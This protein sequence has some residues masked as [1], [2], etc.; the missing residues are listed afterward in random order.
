M[1]GVI[2]LTGC[3]IIPCSGNQAL[4]QITP[5]STLGPE[6]SVV[7]PN[8]LFNDQITEQIDGGAIRGTNLFHS[9]LEFNV[10]NGQQVYFANPI[11]IK[12]IVSRVTGTDS[13]DI[14]GT[15]GVGGGANLFLLNPNG[16][17]FGPNAKLDIGGSFLGSTADS[18]VF[19]NG[20]QFSATNP[21]APPLLTIN[22]PIGL[23][24][25]PNN[26]GATIANRGNLA[27][28][29]DLTLAAGNLDVQGQLQAGRDL[30]L[31]AQHTV[32]V[33]DSAVEPFVAAAGGQLLVQGN[34]KV[35]IFALN[36]PDSGL[37]SGKDMVLR[38][39]NTVG[40]DA[41]YWSGGSFR[42]EQLDG[43]LGDLYSPY[44][45]II[46]TANDVELG[47][48]IGA[49]LHILAGGEVKITGDVII[50]RPDGAATSIG[51]DAPAPYNQQPFRNFTL[52]DQKTLVTIDGSSR[53]T[54]DIRAGIDWSSLPGGLPG[55]TNLFTIRNPNPTFKPSAT[56]ANIEITGNIGIDDP[57][58][59]V[60]LTN[61]YQPDLS[62]VGNIAVDSIVTNNAFGAG[63]SVTLD[64]RGE[65]ALDGDV[66]TSGS[67]MGT[68]LGSGDA[69]DVTFLAKDSITIA[70]GSN[71]LANGEVN[72]DAGD[73][74]F[75]AKDSITIAAGSSILA[76]GGLGGATGNITLNSGGIL[77]IDNSFIES[78]GDSP[79]QSG[80]I[81]FTAKSIYLD[82]DSLV[83]NGSLL[84]PALQGGEV[85]NINLSAS[86]SVQL[87]NGSR[88]V[89]I[90]RGQGEGG[91]LTINADSVQL[92]D[93]GQ[94]INT[95][96]GTGDAGNVI[97]NTRQLVVQQDQK[98]TGLAARTSPGSS[99]RG[100]DLIINA[101]EFIELIGNKPG[102]FSPDINQ[103]GLGILNDIS[104]GLITSTLG[105]GP[106]GDIIIKTGRLTI[107]NGAGIS[108][109][110]ALDST[111]S[112]GNLRVNAT[113]L[114]EI[115]GKAGLAT[116][117]LGSNNAG[118]LIVTAGQV[119]LRD[120]AVI[121]ADSVIGASGNA[122]NI[123]IMATQLS[124]QNGSRVGAVTT[125]EGFGGNVT[126]TASDLVEVVGLSADGQIPSGLFTAALTGS[127]GA[128]GNLTIATRK[129]NVEA[130]GQISASTSGTGNPGNILV[131]GADSVS[132]SNGSI[133]T[134]V[135]PEAMLNLTQAVQGGKIDIQ[136]RTLF[137]TNGA[138]VT[139]STSGQGNAGSILVRDAELV[140]INDHSSISTAVNTGA[141]GQGGNVDIQTQSLSL[142]SG[143]KV[144]A[145]TSGDGQGGTITVSASDA[146]E[147]TASTLTAFTN[148]IRDAGNLKIE[149]S[150]LTVQDG[151]QVSADTSSTGQA[152]TLEVNATESVEVIGTSADGQK[153]SSLFFDSSGTGDAGELT[154]NTSRLL[155]RDGGQVSAATSGDGRGGTLEV[156]ASESVE[157]IGT[158]ADGQKASSLFFDSSGTG[159]AGELI[160]NTNRLLIRDGGQVSAAT[161]GD[162]RGGTLEVNA[163]ESVEVIGTSADGQKASSLFFDS[164]G[165][166]DAGELTINTS[167]LLV[168]DGGQVS[169]ATSGDGRGGT[170]EVRASE[171]V[172]VIGTSADGQKASSL[173]FD[174]S[175]TGDAGELIINTN[176]LL[177]RDGGQVSAATSGD[178]K[179]G[180]LEVNATESVEVIGTSAD[181][182]KAS[183]LFFDSS[184][185]GDAGELTIDTS[186]F[187]V[188]DGGQVSAATSGDGRGGTLEVNATESVEVI[189]T[190]AD[191]QKAS[192]LFFDSSGT[193]DAGEL[194]IDTSRFIVR[195]GGQVSAA[196]SG[197]GRGGVLQVNA[198][199][200]VEVS[201]T[202]ANNQLTS[203]LFF[204][205]RGA[206]DARGI[207][208]NT[209]RLTVQNRGQVTVSG[210]D[211]G[212]S[213]DLEISADSIFLTNQGSLR[214]TTAAAEGGNIRLNVADSIILRHNSE[215]VA[216]AFGTA[217][218]GNITI[219]AGGFIIGVLSE[220]SDVVANAFEGQGGNIY[221][222]AA[223]IFG[224]RQFQDRRTPESD[225]TA[226]SE[227]GIDGTEEIITQNT[228]NFNLPSDVLIEDIPPGCQAS[229]GSA[230]AQS[231][232]SQ[233]F[234][235]GRGGL[236]PNP[237]EA[238]R[239]NI[240]SVP[241]VTL[242]SEEEN[243]TTDSTVTEIVEAQGWV[244]LPNGQIILTPHPP[245]L[246]PSF[247]C[248]LGGY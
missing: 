21:D 185:T 47:G 143:A 234:N 88:V 13:S 11:G 201:G 166:G 119:V 58:G 178:G 140:S 203:G 6:S 79:V 163:T 18:L 95:T 148:S 239:S 31:Q 196:T 247:S 223:G 57:S 97:I 197:D 34:Q 67:W 125:N 142:D 146:V 52:S 134:A 24:Y 170:L 180:T 191:G 80:D 241:W 152:G 195:D 187:I 92:F 186:R 206:G 117:T 138:E 28:G 7:T 225:F 217:N 72:G 210:I 63:G 101:S 144:S 175:G 90:L 99:G 66:V 105:S 220:N 76:N 199:E 85:G 20:S 39:A 77:S 84:N 188:R 205:S 214:A 232:N 177:I 150:R 240:A 136:S 48:Y 222:K 26:P 165:T 40:G 56:S 60:L 147:I 174:S 168:R 33:Q 32:G 169:A 112:G 37:F 141:V 127:T 42:V 209:G 219:D 194:I 145:S 114:L 245:S 86:D 3:L 73:V 55:N 50:D 71:I 27:V 158:S 167:R 78:S 61:Q 35:D 113:E 124:I 17:I 43:S 64:S 135:N 25:G 91:N 183:S 62:L 23:Q 118:D 65:I 12:N 221:A 83:A 36:H 19:D 208:I 69:G 218:G 103:L 176:R 215:I 164:S 246:T 233:F 193:G 130:G 102:P 248:V 89:M 74:T 181:G 111:G 116:S 115:Q 172:E 235:T 161:S 98:E 137:L 8:V 182:Q 109:S 156:R 243:T 30:T 126:V 29:Q 229:S 204:D 46:A 190:S 227:L 122:G 15:L 153:A 44:D 159:D 10:G 128:A 129:L 45:P 93:G 54:L 133:S 228:P 120:G 107:R 132:L 16:I 70:A 212:I 5:D 81:N 9:F 59:M 1:R 49:S 53:A 94:V 14:L 237:H 131:Q 200:S 100:G 157:V 184:G 179:G 202:S 22:V 139:A 192:S 171:S 96:Q 104:A 160:I 68:D 123:E 162:G 2:T 242:N 38:S 121:S 4:A 75:L 198:T 238:L 216:Q 51:P 189:G 106:S 151:G 226:S 211:T 231:A 82:N 110:A 155:V 149:T 230:T 108:S 87:L 213:G 173:F 224:F 207:K 244:K 154:I 236:P 41:H